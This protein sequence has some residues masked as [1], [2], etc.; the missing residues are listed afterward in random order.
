MKRLLIDCD[1]VFDVLTRG[2]FPSGSPEDDGVEQHL[3]ACHECRQLAE[4][5]RPAVELLHEAVA[6]EEACGLPGYQG[7]LPAI[8]VNRPGL[9]PRAVTPRWGSA[10]R[11]LQSL[12]AV[13]FLAASILVAALSLLVYGLTISPQ[14]GNGV[15]HGRVGLALVPAASSGV[16]DG[17]PDETGL[18]QLV[19]LQLPAE[20]FP[21]KRRQ[22]ARDDAG[23]FAAKLASGA[24]EA[25]RCCTECHRAGAGLAEGAA[26]GG[27]FVAIAKESCQACHRS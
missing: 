11:N 10:D 24:S 19:S 22:V 2:P 15:L 23:E 4:A 14:D 5:L 21:P 8:A 26:R 6:A 9:T 7:A 13:R 18:L 3:R 12:A 16:P 17:V 1:Q 27:Q 25:L 20:C